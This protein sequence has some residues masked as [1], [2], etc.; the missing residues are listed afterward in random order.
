VHPFIELIR[1]GHWA[2]RMK[3]IVLLA[4]RTQAKPVKRQIDDWR[5][6]ER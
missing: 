1:R 4:E 6:V 3:R 2:A 5:G